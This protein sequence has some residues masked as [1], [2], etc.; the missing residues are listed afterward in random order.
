MPAWRGASLA[1]SGRVKCDI[2]ASGD[3]LSPLTLTQRARHSTRVQT[4]EHMRGLIRLVA[5]LGDAVY[6]M[7]AGDVQEILKDDSFNGRYDNDLRGDLSRAL[8]QYADGESSYTINLLE[9]K[10]GRV[11][12]PGRNGMANVATQAAKLETVRTNR[13]KTVLS[14]AGCSESVS[15]WTETVEKYRLPMNESIYVVA[16]R[17]KVA[18]R[19]PPRKFALKGPAASGSS[20][21]ASES[22]SAEESSSESD[23]SPSSE[24]ELLPWENDFLECP[25]LDVLLNTEATACRSAVCARS[26]QKW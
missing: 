19:P 8:S 11:C 24:S 4:H 2:I 7:H 15:S 12:V 16:E 5:E 3:A 23:S 18:Q 20:A 1:R 22:D 14:E 13:L 25:H 10:A 21:A 26:T 6:E 17:V 9:R